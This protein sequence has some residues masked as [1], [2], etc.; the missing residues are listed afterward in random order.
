MW[1]IAPIARIG[2]K[3][4]FQSLRG[5]PKVLVVIDECAEVEMCAGLFG[6]DAHDP[7]ERVDRLVDHAGPGARD[8]EIV[9]RLVMARFQFQGAVDSLGEG[10]RG[11][12]CQSAIPR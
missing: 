5:L 3:R 9:Q 8:P 4:S 12:R 2:P 6:V 1:K 10:V 7:V 11:R